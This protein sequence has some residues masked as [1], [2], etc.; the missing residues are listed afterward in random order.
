[1]ANFRT[2][3]HGI[4]TGMISVIWRIEP[5]APPQPIRHCSTCGGSRLF[6]S[7]GRIRL[8]ANGRR[9]DAWLIYK[10]TSCEKTWNLPL[11]E[12]MPVTSIADADLQA[13]QQSDP[14]WVRAREFDLAALARHCD[15]IDI[16]PD[17]TVTKT[18]E[19]GWHDDWSV[20]ALAIHAQ[21]GAGQRLDRL[22]ASELGLARSELQAMQHAGGIQVD[23][24]SGKAL[25][26]PVTGSFTL[27]FIAA[28]LTER[29]RAALSAR[30][31]DG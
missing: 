8:N 16:P 11:A 29:Q 14:A 1:M 31:P 25:R 6:R 2:E 18:V 22:L 21:R 10:C 17:L 4:M 5:L 23:P 24:A 7:S 26:K 19:G 15:R 20:I 27:R 12:R 3:G 30:V 9:L 13:M 28:R